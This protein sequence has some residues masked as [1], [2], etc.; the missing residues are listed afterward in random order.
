MRKIVGFTLAETLITLIIIGVIAVLM[1][2]TLYSRIMEY[3]YKQVWKKDF[4]L[5]SNAFNLAKVDAESVGIMLVDLNVSTSLTYDFINLMLKH[6][7]YVDTCEH[8]GQAG[9]K[10]C[11]NYRDGRK[12]VYT[13]SC[14]LP[15]PYTGY[16]TLGEGTL[17]GYDFNNKAVLLENGSAVYFGGSHSGASIVV[18]VNNCSKGP[19]VLGKDVFAIHVNRDGY[20][21]LPVGAQDMAMTY[22]QGTLGCSKDIGEITANYIGAAAGAGCSAK[23]LYE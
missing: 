18:D 13:W 19:N 20:R 2:P 16:K 8:S 7:K 10:N 12:S 14:V 17:N 1:V 9:T 22:K 4:A 3:E 5:L 6:V 11:D 15:Q 23:Y 21:F